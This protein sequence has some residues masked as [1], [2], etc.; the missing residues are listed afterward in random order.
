MTI[1]HKACSGAAIPPKS[2][3]FIY[4]L[5]LIKF[6]PQMIRQ[7]LIKDSCHSFQYCKKL[8]VS[9]KQLHDQNESKIEARKANTQKKDK[10]FKLALLR[11]NHEYHLQ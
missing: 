5:M 9:A 6:D 1:I 11:S 4:A 2:K 7:P 8:P 10:V 3:H